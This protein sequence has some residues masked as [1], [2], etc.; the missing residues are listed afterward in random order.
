MASADQPGTRLSNRENS[1][2]APECTIC[3]RCSIPDVTLRATDG[4]KFGTTMQNLSPR[5]DSLLSF[6]NSL[7]NGN[8]DIIE[9]SESSQTVNLILRFMHSTGDQPALS[10]Y[11]DR[12]I[13]E[14]AKAVENYRIIPAQAAVKL[15]LQEI[16]PRLPIQVYAFAVQYPKHMSLFDEVEPHVLRVEYDKNTFGEL[17][18]NSPL[19]ALALVKY[20][21]FLRL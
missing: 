10:N 4:G 19:A 11:P 9:L 17:F 12:A 20:E 2:S 16:T 3:S 15:K 8:Q 21:F 7:E 13:V 6:N 5:A 1:I 18:N 14:F